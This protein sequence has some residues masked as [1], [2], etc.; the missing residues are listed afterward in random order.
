MEQTRPRKENMTWV[1]VT[2]LSQ[3]ACKQ[4]PNNNLREF[5]CCMGR[6]D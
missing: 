5:K 6:L 2:V 4:H 3:V 1:V